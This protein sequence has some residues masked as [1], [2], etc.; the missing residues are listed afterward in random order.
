MRIAGQ[1]RVEAVIGFWD[2]GCLE[3]IHTLT[4]EAGHTPGDASLYIR[5]LFARDRRKRTEERGGASEYAMVTLR[6]GGVTGL[7]LEE[8]GT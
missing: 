2:A 3:E 7:C 5:A 8:F 6:F 4:Y 1:E